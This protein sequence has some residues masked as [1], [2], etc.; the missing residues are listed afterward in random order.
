[1]G[2]WKKPPCSQ[3]LFSPG[4]NGCYQAFHDSRIDIIPTPS[5]PQPLCP[6]QSTF[7]ANYGTLFS[8]ALG[9]CPVSCEMQATLNPLPVLLPPSCHLLT[10]MWSL[11]SSSNPFM[12]NLGK[13]NFLPED[14]SRAFSDLQDTAR[15]HKPQC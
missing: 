9:H 7:V 3:E 5:Y 15:Q 1:M 8:S 2:I 12:M 4:W 10:P 6:K 11:T 13:L 14:D